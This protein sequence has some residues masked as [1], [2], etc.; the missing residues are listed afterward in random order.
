MKNSPKLKNYIALTPA[1][2]PVVMNS[3]QGH[4][5]TTFPCQM[6]S[7]WDSV[8]DERDTHHGYAPLHQG[9]VSSHA[10]SGSVTFYSRQKFKFGNMTP[11]APQEQ[12]HSAPKVH[13]FHRYTITELMAKTP[14]SKGKQ[15]ED[16]WSNVSVSELVSFLRGQSYALL[17]SVFCLYLCNARLQWLQGLLNVV[18]K[19]LITVSATNN[20]S[21]MVRAPFTLYPVHVPGSA[22]HLPYIRSLNSPVDLVKETLSWTQFIAGF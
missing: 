17:C 11:C 8:R 1:I 18:T 15:M 6:P 2:G 22:Q 4:P 14:S 16:S 19:E 12:N 7:L 9:P 5:F 20:S 13:I 3:V 10:T 21:N